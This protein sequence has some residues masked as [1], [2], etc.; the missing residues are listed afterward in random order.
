MEGAAG[1][2]GGVVVQDF[3]L[4]SDALQAIASLLDVV[5]EG[6][7]VSRKG[8]GSRKGWWRLLFRAD[9]D[10]QC[11]KENSVTVAISKSS[12]D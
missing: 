7:E 1:G 9:G 5:S 6:A 10:L 8:G 3:Y 2:E 4:P 11:R 12:L